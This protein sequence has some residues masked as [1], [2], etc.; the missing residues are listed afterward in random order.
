MDS[1]EFRI[2]KTPLKWIIFLA[3]LAIVAVWA[4]RGVLTRAQ[5][6]STAGTTASTFASISPGSSVKVVVGIESV[7]GNELKGVLLEKHSDSLYLM[8]SDRTPTVIAALTS[9]TSVVMGKPQDIAV[10]A[11]VQLEG[12]IDANHV[13][14][15]NRIVILSGYVRLSRKAG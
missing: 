2:N 1:H 6:M 10:G 8:T 9:D 11:I 7:E 15:A 5:Q 12:T 4:I 13:L 3:V 14:Q